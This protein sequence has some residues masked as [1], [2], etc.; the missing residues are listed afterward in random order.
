MRLSPGSVC[1]WAGRHAN[2]CKHELALSGAEG[3]LEA[4]AAAGH[5]SELFDFL[6]PD[7]RV[8]EHRAYSAA[9]VSSCRIDGQSFRWRNISAPR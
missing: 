6:M 1:H 4:I 2:F 8:L 7:G 3:T 5:P 9:T